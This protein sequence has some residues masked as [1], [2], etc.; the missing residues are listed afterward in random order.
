V[1]VPGM[2]ELTKMAEQRRLGIKLSADTLQLLKKHA[3]PGNA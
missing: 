2:I 3:A 1:I